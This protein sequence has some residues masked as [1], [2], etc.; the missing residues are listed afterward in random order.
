[1][2]SVAGTA[3]FIIACGGGP[4][5]AGAQSCAAWEISVISVATGDNGCLSGADYPVSCRL[6]DGWEPF[7]VPGFSTITLRRCAR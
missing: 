1:L 6:P 4:R 7:S 3:A 5:S 2:A